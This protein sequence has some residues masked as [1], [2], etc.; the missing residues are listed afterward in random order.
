MENEKNPITAGSYNA[1]YIK[2]AE[3]CRVGKEWNHNIWNPTGGEKGC[4]ALYYRTDHS[5]G[6]AV[7]YMLNGTLELLPGRIYFIPAESV[8]YSEIDG[9]MEKYYI[10]F[11]CHFIDYGL[12]R[13]QYTQCSVPGDAMT[14]YLFQLICRYYKENTPQANQKVQG[15]MHI[16]MADLLNNLA[17]SQNNVEKFKAVLTYVEEHYRENLRVDTL[18]KIMNLNPV[19]FSNS[20]KDSFH[21][22]PKQYI[23]GKKFFKSQQLLAN[24]DLSIKEIADYIGFENENYFYEFFSAKAGISALRYRTITRRQ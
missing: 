12:Y 23:L 24:T 14:E 1:Y 8:L 2:N 11:Y 9:E 18:A 3:F 7:L 15:A 17:V 21:V 22:S 19:Y 10:H 13:H 4:N 16:L 20:F 6:R 5:S